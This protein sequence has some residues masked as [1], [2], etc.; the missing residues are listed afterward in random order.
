MSATFVIV[1][2]TAP[3]GVTCPSDQ[4]PGK[5]VPHVHHLPL[6]DNN[7]GS[8]P[9]VATGSY[10]IDPDHSRIGF[11]ARHAMIT[12]V[13]GSFNEFSG[14]GWFEA[15]DPSRSHLE[16]TIQAKSIDTRNTDRDD[17][18]RTND[19][20]DVAQFPTITFVSTGFER[21]DAT[22][23]CVTG[24]LSIKGSTKSMAIDFEVN[25]T[26]VDPDGYERLG[27]EGSAV[28]NRKDWGVNFNAALDTGGVLV[29]DKIA[30]EF[31]VSAIRLADS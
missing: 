22:T 30:L 14:S 31:D 7:E 11:V 21:L 10:E 25:G 17:H 4:P 23:Y 13:R 1:I 28:I 20:L 18:L 16:L 3:L 26:S 24:D 5:E 27:F 15:D 19:F 2:W 9:L 12:K 8:R 6:T 29:S